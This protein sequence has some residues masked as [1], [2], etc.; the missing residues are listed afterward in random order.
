MPQPAD[1]H[2]LSTS[3]GDIPLHEYRLGLGGRT[4]SILHSDAPIS[5]DEEYFFLNETERPRPFGVALWPS[6]IALAHDIAARD[7]AFR[8]KRVLELGAGVG[9][10][11]IVAATLG[12][13]VTQT[14]RHEAAMVLGRRNGERNGGGIE[15]QVADWTQWRDEVRYDWIVGS[16]ILYGEKMHGHL[17]H[18]LEHNL[19]PGGKALLSDPFRDAS[20]RMLEGM[21]RDGWTV[22][23][24]KWL[25]GMDDTLRA[26]GVFELTAPGRDD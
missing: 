7:G 8:G 5:Y 10:P 6:A 19:A 3:V 15:Y 23:M 12:G 13:R 20:V 24:T 2:T 25:V 9:L 16:D 26:I 1:A 22:G 18:I 14:D 4:W 11:G 21:E 17:R